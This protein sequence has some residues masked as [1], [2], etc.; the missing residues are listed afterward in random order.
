MMRW[1]NGSIS[2]VRFGVSVWVFILASAVALSAPPVLAQST[3][4]AAPA[5]SAS[6][7]VTGLVTSPGPLTVAD[8]QALPSE[9]VAVT[10]ESGGEPEDHTFTGVRLYD[11]LEHLGFAVEPEARNPLLP[12]Y[13]VVTAND[14]YQVVISGGEI[15]PNFGNAPMLLA[16]EQDGAPLEGDDGPLRLVVPGDLRGGRYVHG[17]V[18]I[19]VRSVAGA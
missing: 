8:L 4:V 16:W 18:S 10:Y 19:D 15:D 14:G 3:P 9:T 13:L 17:V 1:L 12:M 5:A 2:K 7:E 11:A 6:I